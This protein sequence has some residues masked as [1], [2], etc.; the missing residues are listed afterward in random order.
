MALAF[1]LL[2]SLG[3]LGVF[4]ALAIITV[5]YGMTG[6][7]TKLM[8]HHNVKDWTRV[9]IRTRVPSELSLVQPDRLG[10]QLCR[11]YD[12]AQRPLLVLLGQVFRGV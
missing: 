9:L 2:P 7:R 11:H 6:R 4:P 12:G 8:T 1:F 5:G 3:D 10:T